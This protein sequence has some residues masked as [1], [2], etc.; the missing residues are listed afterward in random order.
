MRSD[1]LNA[2]FLT[3]TNNTADSDFN[4]TGNGGGLALA[5]YLRYI[6]IIQ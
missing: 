6:W 4:Q 2:Q 3:L 5:G 1:L